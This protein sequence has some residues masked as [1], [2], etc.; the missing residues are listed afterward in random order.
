[1]LE[2]AVREPLVARGR[3]RAARFTWKNTALGTLM[4]YRRLV[5]SR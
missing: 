5:G 2:P 3:A 4:V 1:V